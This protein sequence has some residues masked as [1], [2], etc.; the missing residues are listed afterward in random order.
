MSSVLSLDAPALDRRQYGDA[1]WRSLLYFN[2]YRVGAALIL[3]ASVMILGEDIPFGSYDRRMFLYT[4]IAYVAFGLL[5]FVAI[6]ARQPHFALQ[7]TVQICAD[8]LFIVTMMYA[9]G[10]IGSGLGTLL[11]ISLAAVGLISRGRLTL[12]FAALATL[13]VLVEH[14]YQVLFHYSSTAQYAQAGLLSIGFF[15]TG[16]LAHSLAR[17]AV[18]IEA[19]AAQREIDVANMA[20]VN[21]LVIQDM[22][23][24]VVVVDERGVLRQINTRAEAI[25]GPVPRGREVFLKDYAP[26]LAARME[27]WREDPKTAFDPLRTV[28]THKPTAARFV[29]VGKTRNV[30]VVIFLEDLTRI[31]Q[32]AQQLKLASLGRLTANIAH[33]IR[34]P[35]SAIN[36]ATELLLE[37]TAMRTPA[38]ARMLQIIHDNSRRLDR[39]VQ[40]VLKLNRRDQAL[41]EHFNLADYLRTFAAE[42]CEVEKVAAD[43]IRLE[44]EDAGA[45]P[46]VSF[47]RS[48]LNQVMW[49]LCRN[50]LRYCQKKAGS[51]RLDVRRGPRRGTI[52]LS[53]SDD[54]SGVAESLRGHLFEPFF[55][56]ASSGTGLGLYIAREICEANGATLEYVDRAVGAQF[57]VIC[58]GASA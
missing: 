42:F 17:R 47:D 44:V 20:Q 38:Q 21:Q 58:R 25:L 12:F 46:V 2:F 15:A 41:R 39:M 3:V 11:L 32:Q 23:D 4:D 18:A 6:V 54:G 29:P 13:A 33:E 28:L 43:V 34:N 27:Q 19:I 1:F 35:L 31:Q 16:W 52:E 30:G 24:G 7:L 45:P 5:C 48:H 53:V 57:T 14:T 51:I 8:I 40:D 22:Q 36:H 50:A 56:T 37:E 49:N 26:M 10:G 55:T 9:S